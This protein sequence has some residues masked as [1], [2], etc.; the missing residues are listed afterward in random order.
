M[1][2]GGCIFVDHASGYVHVEHQVNIN[3]HQTLR[4]KEQFERICRDYGVMVQSYLSDNGSVFTSPAFTKHLQ[5]FE[6]VLRYAG[7]GAHHHNGVAER[8]IQTIMAIARTMMLHSSIHWPQ[9]ARRVAMAHGRVL[10]SVPPQPYA[11]LED[12]NVALGHLHQ[13]SLGAQA[14]Q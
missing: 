4:A 10:C 1:F 6:Q 13:V 14:L 3:T 7:V 5:K 8:N 9:V 11:Q 12:R 2:K